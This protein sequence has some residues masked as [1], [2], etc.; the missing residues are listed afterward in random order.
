MT[1]R[2]F[3]PDA[4]LWTNFSSDHLDY[5]GSD[6]EYFMAKLKLADN[7]AHPGN[8][9]IGSSVWAV[10]RKFGIKLNPKFQ[11]I[12]VLTCRDLPGNVANFHKS[13]PS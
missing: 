11:V 9:M 5:H 4:V 2:S 8:V 12:E 3:Y 6:R 7:C 13:I 1:S 10:A